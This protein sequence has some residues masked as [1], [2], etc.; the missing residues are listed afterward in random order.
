MDLKISKDSV[1]A[2]VSDTLGG[3]IPSID[4]RAVSSQVLVDNGETVVLGGIYEETN[5]KNKNKIPLL[6]D[7]PLLGVLF[8]NNS[9]SDN[10]K[11][12]LVFV[13]PKILKEGLNIAH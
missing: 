8:R 12:L 13:T 10:K 6:G 11:E 3:S 4:T 9:L 1:G 7:V 5:T 2:V